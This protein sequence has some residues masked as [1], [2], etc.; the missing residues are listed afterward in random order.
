MSNSLSHNPVDYAS[1]NSSNT[2]EAAAVQTKTAPI[3][4]YQSAAPAN[5]KSAAVAHPPSHPSRNTVDAPAAAKKTSVV[6]R[7][8]GSPS[9]MQ[10]PQVPLQQR[11][12]PTPVPSSKPEEKSL[13]PRTSWTSRDP[14]L[15]SAA[16]SVA[17][18]RGSVA[19]D[20]ARA[21]SESLPPPAPVP[22][23]VRRRREV[24]QAS[25]AAHVYPSVERRRGSLGNFSARA[26]SESATFRAVSEPAPAATVPPFELLSAGRPV[27]ELPRELEDAVSAY[28]MNQLHQLSV[29]D[30]ERIVYAM[31]APRDVKAVM[32][33]LKQQ[34][35]AGDG[36]AAQHPPPPPGSAHATPARARGAAVPAHAVPRNA[37]RD[38]AVTSSRRRVLQEYHDEHHGGA[39]QQAGCTPEQRAAMTRF[40]QHFTVEACAAFLDDAL[41]VCIARRTRCYQEQPAIAKEQG[42]VLPEEHLMP[43]YAR[44]VGSLLYNMTG[45]TQ[46]ESRKLSRLVVSIVHDW[47]PTVV[48]QTPTPQESVMQPQP[49]PA[50][51]SPPKRPP[52]PMAPRPNAPQ[53]VAAS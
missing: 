23:S 26:G 24:S 40:R 50:A 16:S 34:D 15:S 9:A 39:A 11:P 28:Y 13:P 3:P 2:E 10:G 37:P 1:S 18:R 21:G 27:P 33:C 30:Q 31:V 49:A 29:V 32:T 42:V 41:D 5:A 17:R 53:P 52:V 19:Q 38:V 46:P 45:W 51:A 14:M 36:A 47:M 20:P 4:S 44:S 12:N 6:H 48:A 35:H 7:A 25:S 22:T 8:A 43:A